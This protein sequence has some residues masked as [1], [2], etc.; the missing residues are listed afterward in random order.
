MA[1]NQGL[2]TQL[3]AMVTQQMRDR[4]DA[5]EALYPVSRADVVRDALEAG[6]PTVESAGVTEISD[7]TILSGQL[8][9]LVTE[10]MK[11]RID[12]LATEG[13]G[14]GRIVRRALEVGLAS[15]EQRLGA[16]HR[17]TTP[18]A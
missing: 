13:R 14:G 18:G 11:A 3:S 9:V 12:A 6:L 10:E 4:I 5:L 8:S 17:A 15:V 1:R 7:G 2:T 16:R